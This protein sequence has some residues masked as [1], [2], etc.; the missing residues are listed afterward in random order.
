MQCVFVEFSLYPTVFISTFFVWCVFALY[1]QQ[2]LNENLNQK[3]FSL[4]RNTHIHTHTHTHI[5]FDRFPAA[6]A[7]VVIIIVVVVV[8]LRKLVPIVIDNVDQPTKQAQTRTQKQ[9]ILLSNSIITM[10]FCECA[11]NGIPEIQRKKNYTHETFIVWSTLVH[12][13][14]CLFVCIHMVSDYTAKPKKKKIIIIIPNRAWNSHI[15]L[16]T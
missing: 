7:V 12:L 15:Q 4:L 13:F 1:T 2:F 16:D 3:N 10:C 5:F 11:L 8:D 9:M 14:V 6:A